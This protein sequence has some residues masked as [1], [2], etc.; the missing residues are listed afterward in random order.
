MEFEG[1]TKSTT[2]RKELAKSWLKVFSLIKSDQWETAFENSLA[3]FVNCFELDDDSRNTLL[4]YAA[5]RNA[6]IEIIEKMINLGAWRNV[7]NSKG[8]KPIDSAILAGNLHL[9]EVLKPIYVRTVPLEI[10]SKIEQNF[11]K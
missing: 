5:Q 10:L 8:E 4:H 7:R 11:H 9:L 1:V 3:G 2:I 6:P